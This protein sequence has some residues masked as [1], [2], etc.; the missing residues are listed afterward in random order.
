MSNST[1]EKIYIIQIGGSEQRYVKPYK[2]T[3]VILNIYVQ[4]YKNILSNPRVM[5][6]DNNKIVVNELL[7]FINKQS[8]RQI[9]RTFSDPKE[10]LGFLLPDIAVATLENRQD[11]EPKI[12]VDVDGYARGL[13][14]YYTE[15]VMDKLGGEK[16]SMK[17]CE[18]ECSCRHF[19]R[20]LVYVN[21]QK[22]CGWYNDDEEGKYIHESLEEV[23]EDLGQIADVNGYIKENISFGHAK[24]LYAAA[25]VCECCDRHNCNKPVSMF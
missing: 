22:G 11:I 10:A 9:G 25:K 21:S 16:K 8:I 20:I 4:K 2:I 7:G 6:S 14:S 18:C 13:R 17:I 1:D 12:D 15:K 24:E 19:M 3:R 23:L 5:D